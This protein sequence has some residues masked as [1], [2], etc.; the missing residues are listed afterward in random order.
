MR[1]LLRGEIVVE[2]ITTFALFLSA[3]AGAAA[4][5]RMMVRDTKFS[6][7][8]LN[9]PLC[10]GFWV[11]FLVSDCLYHGDGIGIAIVRSFAGAIWSWYAYSKITGE[12]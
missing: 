1:A 9:C 11:G 6:V 2:S 4:L 10:M 8:P 3:C 7:K 5:S 12:H